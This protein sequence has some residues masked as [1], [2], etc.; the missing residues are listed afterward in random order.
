[1]VE[2]VAC[3]FLT[4]ALRNAA[5]RRYLCACVC[6]C[7]FPHIQANNSPTPSERP[8]IQLNSDPIRLE[9]VSDYELRAQSY[10]TPPPPAS[11][12]LSIT[13]PGR[14]LPGLLMGGSN[15]PLLGFS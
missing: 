2:E 12:Q 9:T 6:E 5:S 10:K 8:T 15:D 14:L 11:L 7:E 1:M 4:N 13:S 3:F